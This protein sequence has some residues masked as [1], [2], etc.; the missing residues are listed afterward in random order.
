MK[1]L[2]NFD[3]MKALYP[4]AKNYTAPKHQVK[5]LMVYRLYTLGIGMLLLLFPLVCHTQTNNDPSFNIYDD[6]TYGYGF[7]NTVNTT[8][9]Q[10]D[11]K[12]IVGG[13]FTNYNGT[14]RNRIARR[15]VDGSLDTT[16]N[17]GLGF[18][19]NVVTTSIQADGKIIVGGA[20]NSY[21]G[22]TINRIARLNV[23]GSMDTTFNPGSGFNNI[24]RTTSIQADGK[25]IV[26]GD[27]FSYNGTTINRIARLNPDG[28]LDTGFNPG[29]G[30]IGSP[31]TTSIQA[32]GKIIVGG[33]FSSY[34]GTTINRIAR[35]N[36]DGSLDTGF[37]PG[38]GFI[39]S[40]QTTSIQADG[41]IIVGGDFTAF[42]GTARNYI[43]RL[44]SD[45]SLDTSVNFNGGF[46]HHVHTTSIQADGKIIVGG[47]FSSYN[48]TARNRI[49]R[50]NPDGSLDTTFNPGNGFNSAVFTTSIQADGKIIVGGDF[51]A[52][53]GTARNYIA[54][55]NSDGSLD[56]S[57]N[58]NGG[59]NHHVHTTSIQA[60]GKIIV[61][62]VFSS[63]NVTARNRIARL[64]VDGSLDTTFNP[65]NG[66][67]STVSTI[68]IQADGKIIVGGA[69]TSYNGTTINRIAR[70][71]P[72]GSMDTT[73]NPGSN[74][75]VHTTS[76]QADGKIIV[77]GDFRISRLNPDGYLDMGFNP[78]SVSGS[79]RTTSIQSDGKIIVGGTFTAFNGTT[80]NR[81]ARLNVDGSMDTTF[82]PGSGFNNGVFTTSI[83]S[84]G[85]IIV[86]GFF[87]AYNGTAINYIA[88]LNPDGSLDTGFNPGSGFNF[89][90]L[91]TSIQADGKIIVGGSFTSYNGTAINYIVRLNVDGSMDATFNPG[92][93]FNNAVNTTS[94]QAD[95]KIIV[96]GSFINYDG[97]CRNKI[98]RLLSNCASYGTDILIACDSLTWIDGNTYYASN[99][100]ATYTIIN[101]ATSG[102]DS[103]VTLNLTINNTAYGTDI[104]SSC[105]SLTWIDGNTYYAS[106]NSATYTI[107]NGAAS[108]CDS[109][110]TL[111]LTINNTAYR[112][113]ILSSCDSLTWIDGNTYYASNNSATYTIINGAASGCDS[114]V[115]LN[116]TIN[117]TAYGTDIL[118]SCDS[119]TWIDGNTYYASNNSATYTIINGAASGCDSIVTLNLTINPAPSVSFTSS[120]VSSHGGNDGSIDLTVSGGTV[121][122]TYLWSNG[123]TTEDLS[124]LAAGTYLVTVTDANGCTT[125]Q[126]VQINQPPVAVENISADW[127]AVLYPNPAE[128]QAIADVSLPK[129]ANIRIRLINSLGQ[130]IQSVEYA[131]QTKIQHVFDLSELPAAI[132]FVE[133]TSAGKV[134]TEQLIVTKR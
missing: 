21:N 92:S 30:F 109:V 48:V 86:G 124:G 68:S 69:F 45:G 1:S 85:K 75:S 24:L 49:A 116:L 90:V 106:N 7:N 27:F 8:S 20:F 37:N 134:K 12:I 4:R 88:R 126:S 32:D 100:T 73:F 71:N 53:N 55:L 61:G 50:L 127:T 120:D 119:L 46:N 132:Y 87:T 54:R 104:L 52:F 31:Q 110:V 94:I 57:V 128:F 79:V 91:T 70:L 111:N 101:G 19:N 123:A 2:Q 131:D 41:K 67:N 51:T 102:C 78:S 63:Y 103:I 95:G 99:N 18:N 97:F 96:G 29:S 108:G 72:D 121:L 23:D 5:E 58:F 44:N 42:N 43:A 133:L 130:V 89:T 60:D 64:N 81:I 122:Y 84:D 129:A 25:I 28:S 59:F 6:C 13:S 14:T 66:F 117:N 118:S 16:F 17:P 39:G 9:I 15:N 22:T 56:T 36:P 3:T 105:D 112:T 77:G 83:Q 40:P 11:G 47:G 114:I 26:G 62:G 10:A 82:N 93:G 107:T 38:S 98:A 115:T 34:N 113:D 35:L 80:I 65:G 33:S 74:N 125:T 76:I